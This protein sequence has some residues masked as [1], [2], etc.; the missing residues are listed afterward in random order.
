MRINELK[1]I[2]EENEYKQLE[3]KHNQLKHELEFRRNA[4]GLGNIVNRIAIREGIENRIFFNINYCNEKDLN[5]IKASLEYAETPPEDRE[6]EKKFYLEHKYFKCVNGDSRYF[7]IYESDGT[8]WLNAMDSIMGYKKQ[9]TLKEIEEIKEKFDADL[10]DFEL[11][12]V[13]E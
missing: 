7:Q 1:K 10:A 13:E 9:F 5:M 2:A 8:P 12:E 3:N 11:V 4:G 6:E